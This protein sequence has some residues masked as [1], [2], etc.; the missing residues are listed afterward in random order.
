MDVIFLA[1]TENQK[2]ICRV[3][4][5]FSFEPPSETALS[6]RRGTSRRRAKS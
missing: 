2:K 1:K 6:V 5:C 4:L 3:I